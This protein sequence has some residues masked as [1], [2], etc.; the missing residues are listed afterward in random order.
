VTTEPGSFFTS[1]ASGLQCHYRIY[2]PPSGASTHAVIFFHGL[3]DHCS[4]L[5]YTTLNASIA[6]EL[7]AHVFAVD[8][9]GHGLSEGSAPKLI[10]SW[11]LLVD[12]ATQFLYNVV[13]PDQSATFQFLSHST[14]GAISLHLLAA[15]APE[16]KARF[17]GS[18]TIA[19]L[20]LPPPVPAPVLCVL[21]MLLTLCPCVWANST[22]LS[23]PRKTD[24][25]PWVVF[26][27][28]GVHKIEA[29]DDPFQWK[30]KFPLR[31]AKSM[32]D[33]A[34]ATRTIVA[35]RTL[36][37][38]IKVLHGTFD[39]LVSIE[40]SRL[41]AQKQGAEIWELEREQHVP[42]VGNSGAA[43]SADVLDWLRRGA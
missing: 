24:S 11:K 36:D 4:K 40:G 23:P 29:V 22:A 42:L 10:P 43:V 8:M 33:F 41:L 34:A 3:N 12:D 20:I 19:P 15:M 26:P 18:Y 31:T 37:V 16:T 32:I 28:P 5:Q 39:G 6:R 21:S 7:N 38:R 25:E 9:H 2:A 13:P 1:E 14:G 17:R 27:S 35:T 30:G